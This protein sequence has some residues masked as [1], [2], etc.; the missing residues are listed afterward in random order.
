MDRESVIRE[1]KGLVLVVVHWDDAWTSS[2]TEPGE[3]PMAHCTMGYLGRVT[4]K[5]VELHMSVNTGP[6]MGREF[7]VPF[8][9]PA[10]C[11][12]AITR[13]VPDETDEWQVSIRKVRVVSNKR[14]ARK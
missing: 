1:L 4:K 9:I 14:G 5:C 13:L 8:V 7:D 6:E 11:V 10:G 12:R 2:E 3:R